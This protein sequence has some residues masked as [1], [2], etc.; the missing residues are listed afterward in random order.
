MLRSGYPADARFITTRAFL[1]ARDAQFPHCVADN[2][3]VR[4]LKWRE[5]GMYGRGAPV[6]AVVPSVT[7]FFD[8]DLGRF[9]ESHALEK[10]QSSAAFPIL[11]SVLH[12]MGDCQFATP[13]KHLFEVWENSLPI[14]PVFALIERVN[15]RRLVPHI[16]VVARPAVKE[17]PVHATA[18]PDNLPGLYHGRLVID[19]RTGQRIECPSAGARIARDGLH[20]RRV[21]EAA[22]IFDVTVLDNQYRFCG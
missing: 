5:A 9:S 20:L 14:P 12:W 16:K 13:A 1:S 4:P 21:E 17:L 6:D 2:V 3:M 15:A 19:T 8:V 10:R 7:K 22:T 11:P 18:T